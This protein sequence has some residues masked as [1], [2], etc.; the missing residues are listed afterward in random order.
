MSKFM[1]FDS[2]TG[3]RVALD[4]NLITVMEDIVVERKVGEGDDA[5][6]EE[7]RAVRVMFQGSNVSAILAGNVTEI[8]N[9]VNQVRGG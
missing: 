4:P 9:R 5:K 8:A 1:F 2:I 7:L 3:E 6:T